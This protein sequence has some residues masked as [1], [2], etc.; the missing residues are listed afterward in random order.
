MHEVKSFQK[1]THK[2]DTGVRVLNDGHL[3]IFIPWN[4]FN[5]RNY[6]V[7]FLCFNM[8]LCKLTLDYAEITIIQNLYQKHVRI[9]DLS[10]EGMLQAIKDKDLRFLQVSPK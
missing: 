10:K 2:F 9:S 4:A 8:L 1:K 6:I 5:V 3:Q 7:M